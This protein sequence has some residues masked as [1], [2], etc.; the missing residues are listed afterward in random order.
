VASVSMGECALRARSAGEVASASMD[1]CA[2]LARSAEAVT[3]AS[4]DECAHGASSANLLGAARRCSWE[5]G[6][7]PNRAFSP[8]ASAGRVSL[9]ALCLSGSGKMRMNHRPSESLPRGGTDRRG[10]RCGWSSRGES[11]WGSPDAGP[12]APPRSRKQRYSL[13]LTVPRDLP[14]GGWRGPRGEVQ[15][16]SSC[17]TDMWP[18]PS[19]TARG[20]RP[21]PRSQSPSLSSRDHCTALPRARCWHADQCTWVRATS[22][23]PGP[24]EVDQGSADALHGV[25]QLLVQIG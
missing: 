15:G 13:G 14:G 10:E 20:E 8:L 17:R 25:P 9:E 6:L 21:F 3:S 4:M 19:P 16:G 23:R 7:W 12:N 22:A 2:L 1:E 18:G 24:Q 11:M 5:A